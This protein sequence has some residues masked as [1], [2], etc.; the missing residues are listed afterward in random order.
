MQ[1]GSLKAITHQEV[2]TFFIGRKANKTKF[3]AIVHKQFP[4][5]EKREFTSKLKSVCLIN[6]WLVFISFKSEHY[7]VKF[8][9]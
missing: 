4:F 5:K 1:R 8:F 3:L 6:C 9:L 2:S 7:H